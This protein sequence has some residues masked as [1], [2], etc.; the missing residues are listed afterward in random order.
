[1]SDLRSWR[2]VR[3]PYPDLDAV[4]GPMIPGQVVTVTGSPGSGRSMFVH[5]LCRAAAIAQGRSVLLVTGR[6][7]VAEVG[8]RLLSAEARVS[9][10]RLRSGELHQPDDNRLAAAEAAIR[11]SRLVV[12]EAPPDARRLMSSIHHAWL[13][14]DLDLVVIDDADDLAAG[15]HDQPSVVA[16]LAR[17]ATSMQLPI[18]A[19]GG[20]R[21][22]EPAP[23]EPTEREVWGPPGDDGVAVSVAI[24]VPDLFKG[25]SARP[26]EADLVVRRRDADPVTISLSFQAHYSRFTGMARPSGGS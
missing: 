20:L 14:H 25:E 22:L 24:H 9:R 6:I 13:A 7:P 26:G 15:G 12:L 3:Y 16:A 21:R 4:L 10:S 5:D 8:V 1:M 2:D 19:T 11:A 23:E 18:V 17:G